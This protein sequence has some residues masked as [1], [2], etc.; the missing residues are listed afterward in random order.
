[1]KPILIAGNTS[2]FSDT[3]MLTV[4]G[5][6]APFAISVMFHGEKEDLGYMLSL[7]GVFDAISMIFFGWLSDRVPHPPILMLLRVG[8]FLACAYVAMATAVWQAD[9]AYALFG[10]F[11]AS[12]PVMRAL[13][14]VTVE[15]EELT[16]MYGYT[17]LFGLASTVTAPLVVSLADGLGFGY[18]FMFLMAG[19]P[20]VISALLILWAMQRDGIQ[21]CTKAKALD[22]A[23]P[24]ADAP[25]S[26]EAAPEPPVNYFLIFFQ[27]STMF[28]KHFGT[29]MTNAVISLLLQEVLHMRLRDVSLLTLLYIGVC[30]VVTMFMLKPLSDALGARYALFVATATLAGGSLAFTLLAEPFLSLRGAP[31]LIGCTV[32]SAFGFTLHGPNFFVVF[33]ELIPK[34]QT[35]SWIGLN[36]TVAALARAVS[37]AVGVLLFVH[38]DWRAPY[39][40]SSF[41]YLIAAIGY[42]WDAKRAEKAKIATLA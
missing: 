5:L 39:W 16:M 35:G 18:G 8:S 3:F 4:C 19:M 34:D 27:M 6:V 2:I 10:V 1:M 11:G 12:Q 33:T 36:S 7:M 38:V 25:A 26:A 41:L 13:T 14:S 29:S 20:S 32:T 40:I 17:E 23:P 37:P 24:K 22:E 42:L 31:V 28:V 30:V 15:R 9:V 21:W